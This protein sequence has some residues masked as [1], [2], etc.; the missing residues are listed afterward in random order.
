MKKMLIIIIVLAVVGGIAAMIPVGGDDG[1]EAGPTRPERE[2]ELSHYPDEPPDRPLNLLFIHHSVGGTLLADQGEVDGEHA[3]QCIWESHPNGGGL[4]SLL[5]KAGYRVHEASY[6]SK[7][8]ENTDLFDW[9]PKF[10]DQMDD[11]LRVEVQ[12]QALEGDEVNDI[13]VFK[14]CFP[15][16]DFT[17]DGMEPGDPSGPELTIANAQATLNA[18][19]EQLAQH[20][21]T[22]FVYV[23]AP[24]LAPPTAQPLWKWLAKTILGRNIDPQHQ[25]QAAARAR[26]FNNWVRSPEGWLRDYP[27]NNIVVF[28]YYN[29]LTDNGETNSLRYPTGDGSDSH[30]AAD[31]NRQAAS[32]FLPF[33]NRAVRRAGLLGTSTPTEVAPDSDTTPQPTAS[34]DAGTPASEDD[35]GTAPEESS[36]SE[37][38][39]EE[40]TAE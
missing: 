24:P 2:L 20:P 35:G 7:I 34:G 26:Q 9:L 40:E 8:G 19:R 33:I 29:L 30:P 14:S 28:D 39:T 11:V 21:N 5:T 17:S 16:N 22:L 37:E 18:L 36:E 25:R 15:N 1:Q 6:G 27:H 31:G 10:R 38:N 23:T 13:V 32:A 3:P 4:R 12:D